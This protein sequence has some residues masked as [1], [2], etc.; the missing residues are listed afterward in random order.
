MLVSS[1]RVSGGFA[2]ILLGTIFFQVILADA[3]EERQR[4]RSQYLLNDKLLH[5]VGDIFWHLGF[6]S[7]KHPEKAKRQIINCCDFFAMIVII[8]VILGPH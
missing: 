8:F 7:I 2:L 1:S 3:A 4:F 5:L 6:K